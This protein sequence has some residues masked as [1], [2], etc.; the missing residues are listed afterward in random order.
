MSASNTGTS[1]RGIELLHDPRLNG[2]GVA[3]VGRRRVFHCRG[4]CDSCITDDHARHVGP[5]GPL[6]RGSRQLR[7]CRLTSGVARC[8]GNPRQLIR[9]KALV[10]FHFF[11]E[12]LTF[13]CFSVVRAAP[14]R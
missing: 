14:I 4:R 10:H 13:R 2:D 9:A 11:R 3:A 7:R 1:K 6:R 12:P 8:P 5:L